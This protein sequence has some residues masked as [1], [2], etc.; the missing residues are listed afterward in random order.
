MK[1]QKKCN[2]NIGD[3]L[4]N[5]IDSINETLEN[6]NWDFYQKSFFTDYEVRPFNSR[7]HHW[8]P[9]T[10]VPE[11][12]FTL[13]EV[14]TE[15]KATIFDPF[16]G[17]GTT[18]FQALLLNRKPVS[19][20]ICR[21]AIEYM[22]SLFTLFNPQLDFQKLREQTF[23][24]LKDFNA[25]KD[26]IS[27]VPKRILIEKLK[28][29][30]T[31]KTLNELSFLFIK[32]SNCRKKGIKS[33]F[34]ISISAILK[35]VSSQN[36]GWGCIADNVKPKDSQKEKKE[37]F[38]YF[39]SH[40]KSL[41]TDIFE[42][43]KYVSPEYKENYKI[44]KKK[45]RIFYEDVRKCS[46][47]KDNSVDLV[48]TSPPYPNMTDYVTSQ[49][50]SYYFYGIDFSKKE[51]KENRS[52]EIGARSKR[53][54]KDSI[55][56]YLEDMK[57]ANKTIA[58]KIKKGGYACYVMP[59]FN[60][61]NENNRLRKRIVDKLLSSMKDYSLF[62]Q[63]E[64]IRILPQKRRSHNVKWTTLEKEKIHLFKKE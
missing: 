16:S 57:E 38:H 64:Y 46:E 31:Q 4:V 18:F 12:P 9:A 34:R 1:K 3:L 61:D 52:A 63:A 24:H 47:I 53:A 21:V 49:R 2:R 29:W 60:T 19:T 14:L 41:L 8:Y 25:H 48:V 44:L 5:D 45:H 36:R 51:G 33:L 55:E 22:R 37:V 26:Y 43:L 56:N 59:V 7:K 62:K 23:D 42:H 50:L 20:E 32:E 28:P 11:I 39:K 58:Q 35:T 10:F 27:E 30:Y 40:A 54:R 13:I 6:V 17:I 15:P